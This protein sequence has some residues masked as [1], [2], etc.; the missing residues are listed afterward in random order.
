MADPEPILLSIAEYHVGQYA[1][2]RRSCR[3]IAAKQLKV[4]LPSA[5]LPW[6]SVFC[7][8]CCVYARGL[9]CWPCS[10][11]AADYP[12]KTHGALPR[13]SSQHSLS[14]PKSW[15]SKVSFIRRAHRVISDPSTNSTLRGGW[16][17]I[18]NVDLGGR[19]GGRD[20]API[21]DCVVSS[22]IYSDY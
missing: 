13:V 4:D 10:A 9:H 7:A 19:F 17:L 5:Q 2:E 11:L 16:C 1:D 14:A 20:R 22:T 18:L 6:Q 15:H 12:N 8:L 21:S 3:R